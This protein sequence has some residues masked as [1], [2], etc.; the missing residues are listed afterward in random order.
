MKKLFFLAAA[1]TI[2]LSSCV[3]NDTVY[4]DAQTP[5]EFKA[6]NVASTKAPIDGITFDQNIS[7]FAVYNNSGKAYFPETT[8]E[9]KEAGRWG[10]NPA[11]YWPTTGVMDFAAYSPANAGDA[12]PTY[13]ADGSISKISVV[14]PDNNAA[15]Q[16]DIIYGDLLDNIQ[17]PQTNPV[18]MQFHHALAQIVLKFKQGV[19]ATADTY[20]ITVKRVTLKDLVLG[21]TLDITPAATSTID[22]SKKNTAVAYE[23]DATA[24]VLTTDFTAL[25][26]VL[27][28]PSAQ[29]SV[30]IV[31]DINV[32]GN[33]NEVT[34]TVSLNTS[35][36]IDTPDTWEAGKKYTYNININ[37]KEIEFNPTVTDWVVGGENNIT[38][39]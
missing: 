11:R 21:G 5:M 2:A 20:Q 25:K 14:C 17:C 10:G 15:D 27:V 29:T 31:Y 6:F 39:E 16:K 7:V 8:F 4:T 32:D 26:G 22:W 37:L 35:T 18:A 19:A 1:A 24:H 38:I 9:K 30:E 23:V 34:Q 3:K 28:V 13:V 33:T 36:D 12:T